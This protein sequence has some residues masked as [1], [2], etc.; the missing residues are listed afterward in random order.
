M[1]YV[2]LVFFLDLGVWAMFL[3]DCLIAC[4]APNKLIA[5]NDGPMTTGILIRS[6]RLVQLAGAE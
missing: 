6:E 5:E 4:S 3:C 2:N 1:N